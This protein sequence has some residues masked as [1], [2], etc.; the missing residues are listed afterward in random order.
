MEEMMEHSAH[1][2]PTHP[3]SGLRLGS[4]LVLFAFLA[5]AGFYL[6][7]EHTAHVFGILPYLLVFLCPIL[8]LLHGGHG[9]QG[10]HH[11]PEKGAER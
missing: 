5:I 8:H 10:A 2:H 7:T 6:L 11:Q 3:R 1:S 9:G 4:R